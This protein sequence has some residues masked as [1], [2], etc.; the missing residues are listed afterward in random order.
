M[1]EKVDPLSQVGV[2]VLAVRGVC[3]CERSVVNRS[4]WWS[5]L[6]EPCTTRHVPADILPHD[7][8]CF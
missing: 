7:L 5:S 8:F 4:G 1:I 3:I 6:K 2:R